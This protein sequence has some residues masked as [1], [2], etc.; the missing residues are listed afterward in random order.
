MAS[1][2]EEL[3][4]DFHPLC[5]QL[6]MFCLHLANPARNRKETDSGL[7]SPPSLLS[8]LLLNPRFFQQEIPSKQA[9]LLNLYS[10]SPQCQ[11]V[12]A[13]CPWALSRFTSSPFSM[14]IFRS[15][16]NSVVA[17]CLLVRV[18]TPGQCDTASLEDA[19]PLTKIWSQ[20]IS[21]T[22]PGCLTPA[23]N[24]LWYQKVIIFPKKFPKI[25]CYLKIR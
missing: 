14:K 24:L 3:M 8:H 9:S 18:G 13:S 10:S 23:V 4:M 17:L 15:N 21:V 11:A 7:P 12:P 1:L 20:I 25:T 2:S 6:P 16:W 5:V 22:V 19:N